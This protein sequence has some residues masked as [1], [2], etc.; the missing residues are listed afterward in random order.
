[1]DSK[2]TETIEGGKGIWVPNTVIT[3]NV[4]KAPP[5]KVTQ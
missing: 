5:A 1:V 2:S 3:V 4:A